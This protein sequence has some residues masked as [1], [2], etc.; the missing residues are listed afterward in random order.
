MVAGLL[1]VP[2]LLDLHLTVQLPKVSICSVFFEVTKCKFTKSFDPN[3]ILNYDGDFV[4]FNGK[5]RVVY[6]PFLKQQHRLP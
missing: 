3:D 2:H 5:T 4:S 6:V 1:P